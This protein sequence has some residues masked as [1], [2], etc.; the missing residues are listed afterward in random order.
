M[1]NSEGGNLQK[2]GAGTFG[3]CN[4]TALAHF[5]V[6]EIGFGPSWSAEDSMAASIIRLEQEN[7]ELR[8]EVAL[9]REEQSILKGDSL[10]IAIDAKSWARLSQERDALAEALRE[11]QATIEGLR[12]ALCSYKC[13]DKAAADGGWANI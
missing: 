5:T 7:Q 3:G 9:L 4:Q 12:D 13:A 10:R 2:A 8:A 6:G 1:N 11:S